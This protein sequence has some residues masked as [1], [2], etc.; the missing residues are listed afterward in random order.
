MWLQRLLNRIR[1]GS[2]KVAPDGEEGSE[3]LEEKDEKEAEEE[4]VTRERSFWSESEYSSDESY[5]SSSAGNSA[6]ARELKSSRNGSKRSRH[7]ALTSP[8]L[9]LFPEKSNEH[10]PEVS[11]ESVRE[12]LRNALPNMTSQITFERDKKAI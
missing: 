12:S 3:Q 9:S 2:N 7:R 11:S 6:S 4:P 10:L 8:S 1:G 5:H